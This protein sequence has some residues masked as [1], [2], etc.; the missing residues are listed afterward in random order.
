MKLARAPII[1]A[2]TCACPEFHKTFLGF[3]M[4]NKVKYCSVVHAD[5]IIISSVHFIRCFLRESQASS[6]FS[7][8][9]IS[10]KVL[11]K[12]G[13]N[14]FNYVGVQR[15]LFVFRELF[16]HQ[17]VYVYSALWNRYDKQAPCFGGVDCS[18]LL[19]SIRLLIQKF[20]VC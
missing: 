4:V 10:V 2:S 6:N 9:C 19:G 17:W 5:L 15:S 12:K 8:S 18:K 3:K 1:G 11:F 13:T 7:V 20:P 14:Q 16:L